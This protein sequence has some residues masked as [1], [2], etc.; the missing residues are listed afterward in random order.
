MLDNI[1]ASLYLLAW[2]LTLILYQ[3]KIRKT[4]KVGT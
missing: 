4:E 1:L 3:W 2:V